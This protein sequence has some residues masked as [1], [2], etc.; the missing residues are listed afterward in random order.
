MRLR[1]KSSKHKGSEVEDSESVIG[2]GTVGGD[3]LQDSSSS[4]GPDA[5]SQQPE[6]E[7]KPRQL[8]KTLILLLRDIVFAVIIVVIVLASVLAYTRV[9]PPMVVIESNSMQHGRSVSYLGVIDTGD[10]VLV[11]AASQRSDVITWVEGKARGHITYSNYGD[12]IIF[13]SDRGGTPIIHRPIIWLEYNNA[14]GKFDAP[15][16]E[17]LDPSLWGGTY[18]NSTPVTTPYG[19]DG[20][21]EI[22]ESGWK[23]N[24]VLIINIE[25]SFVNLATN[26]HSG[27]VTLGDNNGVNYD[28]YLVRQEDIIGK[29]RGELP[30]FGLIKLTIDPATGKCCF[31]WGD[32]YAPKNSWDALVVALI[33]MI[34][35][36]IIIDLIGVMF[37]R[38]LRKRQERRMA[39]ETGMDVAPS[40]TTDKSETVTTDTTMEKVSTTA[41]IEKSGPEENER[42]KS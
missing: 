37:N 34:T 40:S 11:Q 31:G 6:T 20:T 3:R 30:W 24:D 17:Q 7:K 8:K 4:L 21:L 41:E 26:H 5:E 28:G 9:W 42:R 22:S 19:L 13:N 38:M 14:S 27:Y 18:K 1:L 15:D 33:L 25:T 39:D 2:E 23:G 29:A 12:V 16:L 36:P 10:L 35:L 32:P